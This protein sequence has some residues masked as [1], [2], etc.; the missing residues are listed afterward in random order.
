MKNINTNIATIEARIEKLLESNVSAEK[1]ERQTSLSIDEI[2]SVRK[3]GIEGASFKAIKQ[4]CIFIAQYDNEILDKAKRI[5]ADIKSGEEKHYR[6][7]KF[8]PGTNNQ[9]G[10]TRQRLGDGTYVYY[11]Y[12]DDGYYAKQTDSRDYED[13]V[14]L[15]AI[16]EEIWDNP[17][18]VKEKSIR[19]PIQA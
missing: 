8:N 7:N 19:E 1:I 11:V 13:E 6:I 10:I 16:I 12:S 14:I 4:L 15:K 2:E 5:L 3:N 17:G 9:H 18:I